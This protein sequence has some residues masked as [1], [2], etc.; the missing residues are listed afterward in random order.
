[1]K[2]ESQT[3]LY[4]KR[5]TPDNWVSPDFLRRLQKNVRVTLFDLKTIILLSGLIFQQLCCICVFT[6]CFIY[7]LWSWVTAGQLALFVTGATLCGFL[8]WWHSLSPLNKTLKI[9]ATPL[10]TGLVILT[11]STALAPV[12]HSLL[13]TVSTDT[14][15]AMT[16]LFLL[17]NWTLSPYGN[18]MCHRDP[19]N[20]DSNVMSLAAGLLASL[21][22]SSR[23]SGP[24]ETLV[25]ILFATLM[26]A[27]WPSI[28]HSF[29]A[30]AAAAVRLTFTIGLGVLALLSL[31]PFLLSA[32]IEALYKRFLLL[33]CVFCGLFFN[34]GIPWFFYQLQSAKYNIHG[35]W[36]EAI[37][38]R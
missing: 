29:Q 10:H 2:S 13:D 20:R 32:E 8:L 19:V 1:M 34:L 5:A 7:L 27:T 18:G 14:I 11:F 26:F 12:L 30:D 15:Y 24:W 16:F 33:A 4:V 31:L 28:A 6:S 21:C 9:L 36:D 35:P 25:L 38:Q 37:I 17:L 3:K 23:L 22:L